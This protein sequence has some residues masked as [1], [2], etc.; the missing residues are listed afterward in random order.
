[1]S[2]RCRPPSSERRRC[3]PGDLTDVVNVDLVD[4]E[5]NAREGGNYVIER[6]AR[7]RLRIGF[8]IN[9][10]FDKLLSRVIVEIV[11]VG[12]LQGIIVI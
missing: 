1:M 5:G 2:E 11:C 3:Y 10:L 9:R 12:D 4:T 7:H 8:Y 6:D